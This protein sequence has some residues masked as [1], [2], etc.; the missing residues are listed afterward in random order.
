MKLT[1]EEKEEIRKFEL[2]NS[3]E[4][5]LDS[6]KF[7]DETLEVNIYYTKEAIKENSEFYEPGEL[8]TYLEILLL[9]KKDRA[10]ENKTTK[11]V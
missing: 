5:K 3:R 9:I 1:N 4:Y 8:E 6:V 2:R 10:L 11:Q 7:D